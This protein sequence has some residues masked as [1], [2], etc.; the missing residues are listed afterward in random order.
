M[1]FKSH[2]KHLL[3][4]TILLL[5]LAS[6]SDEPQ[7]TPACEES[8]NMISFSMSYDDGSRSDIDDI[9]HIKPETLYVSAFDNDTLLYL[10]NVPFIMNE[11]GLYRPEYPVYWPADKSKFLTFIVNTNNWG[12]NLQKNRPGDVYTGSHFPEQY[13]GTDIPLYPVTISWWTG[14]AAPYVL[15]A[16]IKTNHA[17]AGDNPISF[18]FKIAGNAYIPRAVNYDPNTAIKIHHFMVRGGGY[19]FL[20]YDGFEEDANVK[21]LFSWWSGEYH[22][23]GRYE[24]KFVPDIITNLIEEAPHCSYTGVFNYGDN[25]EKGSSFIVKYSTHNPETGEL[26]E[27]IEKYVRTDTFAELLGTSKYAL[28]YGKVFRLTVEFGTQYKADVSSRSLDPEDDDPILRVEVLDG[29]DESR[30]ISSKVVKL[31]DLPSHE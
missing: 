20:H 18:K 8:N 24:E 2:L 26:I 22:Y 29:S 30:S 9:L 27:K 5:S 7:V 21:T 4:M 19:T 23:F 17:I 13:E 1:L 6:C 31:R 15:P 28:L 11:D 16:A 12:T 10:Y 25:L 3:L 14:G